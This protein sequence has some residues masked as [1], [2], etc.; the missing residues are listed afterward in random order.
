MRYTLAATMIMGLFVFSDCGGGESGPAAGSEGGPCYGN[1]TCDEGLVC[2]DDNICEKETTDPCEGVDCS[3]H[4]DCALL[5]DEPVCVCDDGYHAEGLECVEDAGTPC[6]GVDCS[7]HGSC[8]I[9]QNG[10]PLCVCDDGYHADGLSCVE[11][12]DA[13]EGET[14]SGHGE[15]VVDQDGDPMCVCDDGYHAEGLKCVEDAG[16]PCEDVDCSGHGDC[17]VDQNGDPLCVCDDGYHADGL[18]C[19]EDDDPCEGETCS[20]HG[21]CV[22]DQNGDPLCLCDDGYHAE[23]LEC[24]EDVVDCDLS[25]VETLG[26]L[27]QNLK[28]IATR[29]HNGYIYLVGGYEVN[30]GASTSCQANVW[31]YDTADDQLSDLG[32]VLPYARCPQGNAEMTWADNGKLYIA[33]GLGPSV[34]NGWGSHK[35]VI[36]FDPDGPSAQEKACFPSNRWNI[37]VLNGGNGYLYF[38]GGWNGSSITDIYRYDPETDELEDTGSNISAA[39]NRVSSAILEHPDGPAYIWSTENSGPRLIRFDP[40]DLSFVDLADIDHKAT[41][42]WLGADGAIHTL[43]GTEPRFSVHMKYTIDADTLESED[44]GSNVFDDRIQPAFSADIEGGHLYAFGGPT[45]ESNQPT[46]VMERTECL[47]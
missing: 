21:E 24:V 16:S 8:A 14:C 25:L 7:G 37:A 4:G 42:T 15:C 31:R 39:G 29:P 35:C 22:V 27:P 40:D 23:G 34:N 30:S 38:L 43:T 1:G 20:G 13:C 47:P 26:D 36:E 12:E 32:T 9:D 18:S 17:A 46:D 10:D 45:V 2:N 41:N 44:L 3:G 5:D 28:T 6:E 19:V 11:D 33:P